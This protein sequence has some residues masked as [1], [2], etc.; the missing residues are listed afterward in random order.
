MTKR[1]FVIKLLNPRDGAVVGY[2]QRGRYVPVLRNSM[3]TRFDDAAE[4][5]GIAS[6][7]MPDHDFGNFMAGFYATKP[8]VRV[9]EVIP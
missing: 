7:M 8:D 3:A 2:W 1:Y 4:A 6:R 9:V 5:R